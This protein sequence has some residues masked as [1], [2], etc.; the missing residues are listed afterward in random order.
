[1][2]YAIYRLPH[3]DYATLI[4]QTEGEPAEYLFCSELNGKRGFVVAPFEVKE[5]QPIFQIKWR[6]LA[7]EMVIVILACPFCRLL[8]PR[9]RPI[10]LISPIIMPNLRQASSVRLFWLVV[11]MKNPKCQSPRYNS[12]IGLV[13]FIPECLSL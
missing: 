2:S 4:Q 8:N 12:S 3:A 9:Q 10:P 11:S 13:R 6:R 7:L 5:Q 1:M